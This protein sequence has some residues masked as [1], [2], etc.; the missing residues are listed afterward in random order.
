MASA[1][2]GLTMLVTLISPP[3]VQLRGKVSSIQAGKSLTLRD[4]M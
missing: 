4:G 2:L 1:F 3:G